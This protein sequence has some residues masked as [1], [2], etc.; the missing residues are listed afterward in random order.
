M[1]RREFCVLALALLPV[2]SAAAADVDWVS[3]VN[4]RVQAIPDGFRNSAPRYAAG[5]P[6]WRPIE[7][8]AV[9]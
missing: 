1:K 5:R 6:A 7:R 9:R 2:S 4:S 8:Q 3:D